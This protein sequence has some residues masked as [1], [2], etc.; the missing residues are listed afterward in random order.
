MA[1]STICRTCGEYFDI[2]KGGGAQET[3]KSGESLFHR[4]GK[5]VA[6]EKTVTIQCYACNARQ[7]VSNMA[8]SSLCPNCSNYIDLRDHKINTVFSRS[9]ETQGVVTIAPKGDVSSAKIVC[10]EAFIYGKL[11]G[12]FTC[13]G[14]ALVKQKG[15]ILGGLNIGCLVV[16]KRSDVEFSRPV[17]V[18]SAEIRGKAYALITATGEVR[19]TNTGDL[20]G[21]IHAKSLTVE[22]G[23]KFSGEL[24]IG[25]QEMEQQELLPLAETQGNDFFGDSGPAVEPA[26]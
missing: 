20:E 10:R 21:S 16:D 26:L 7:T 4:I 14:K 22:K 12:Q 25:K 19:I 9:I 17:K 18:D 8:K 6:G 24:F 1:Q 2:S 3:G 5:Y 15:K 23:G 13:T 11:R